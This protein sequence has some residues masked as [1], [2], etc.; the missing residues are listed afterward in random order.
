MR[1]MKI[2]IFI[3]VSCGLIFNSCKKNSQKEWLAKVD[4]N[5]ITVDE[6]NSMYYTQLSA[7]YNKNKE[8]IDNLAND[9]AEVTKNPMLNKSEFLVQLINQRLVYNKA[10]KEGLLDKKDVKAFIQMTQESAVIQLYV[11]EKFEKD[12]EVTDDEIG[13]I[14][15]SQKERFKGAPIEQAEQYIRSNLIQQKL[16]MKV[17]EL[18]DSLRDEAK[19]EKRQELLSSEKPASVSTDKKEIIGEEKDKK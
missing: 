6:F 17:K 15:S 2:I 16:Q 18:V 13:K 4:G 5:V 11:K 14:Y 7:L 9:P 10:V 12:I 1:F 8:E 19:I 3:I